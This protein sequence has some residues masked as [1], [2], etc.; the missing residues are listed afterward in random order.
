MKDI[1]DAIDAELEDIN[2][3]VAEGLA[4][5]QLKG[6]HR[7]IDG[8]MKS[9][10]RSSE[11]TRLPYGFNYIG[12][13][14]LAPHEEYIART[15][16][17]NQTARS[18]SRRP[19]PQGYEFTAMD[20][21]MVEFEFEADGGKERLV[22]NLSM[23]FARIGGITHIRG[24]KY[25]ISA[26]MKTRAIS[27]TKDGY[28]IEFQSSKLNI[29]REQCTFTIDGR[30][31]HIHLPYSVTLH[32][33]AASN[34]KKT[35]KPALAGWL[36]AKYGIKY[37]F[38]E[39]LGIDYEIYDILDERLKTLDAKYAICHTKSMPRQ[40][41]TQFVFVVKRKDLNA[42]VKM[43]IGSMFYI[44]RTNP[45][46]VSVNSINNSDTWRVMLG[47]AIYADSKNSGELITSIE[48]HF[49]I[50]ENMLDDQYRKELLRENIHVNNI[51]ELL[52]YVMGIFTG[53]NKP[54]IL[55]PSAVWGR[56]LTVTE[57]VT[58]D[59]RES[60]YNARNELLNLASNVL[61]GT[62]GNVVSFSKIQQTIN[63]KLVTDRCESINK[64]H[65]EVNAFSI[66]TQ[67]MF[68]GV[69]CECIDQTEAKK[70]SSK[71]S[72]IDLNDERNHYNHEFLEVGSMYSLPKPRPI[73]LAKLNGHIRL[74]PSG[75]IQEREDYK[76]I[77]ADLKVDLS[78]KGAVY[79]EL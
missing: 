27:P 62:T 46:I 54:N 18:T 9:A 52:Y 36:F 31:E 75:Q 19:Q 17:A 47:Q 73:G 29:Y 65:G 24:V 12:C 8:V 60:I 56:Y 66:A 76:D 41:D 71:K 44:A 21:Y 49:G 64:K 61:D 59:I 72:K 77:K 67:N 16:N 7:V 26:V 20:N 6:V 32:H 14:R 4:Y 51:F 2:P 69:T 5:H 57:Y 40:M 74:S 50:I 10:L 11:D 3:V 68:W 55:R 1:L 38:N 43:F 34:K 39:L 22:R 45:K 33:S 78:Y 37:V 25:K 53:R 63:R 35:Y 30:D 58:F 48:K 79:K 70:G 15:K 42:D 28:F 13:R 23:P